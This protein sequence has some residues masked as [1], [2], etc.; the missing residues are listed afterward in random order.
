MTEEAKTKSADGRKSAG[1]EEL[2]GKVI[3]G[4]TGKV[5]L[6]PGMG[7]H[8]PLPGIIAIALYMLV[9]GAVVTFGAIGKHL[10]M[11]MLVLAPFFITASFGLLRMFRW[12]WALT[13]AAVFLLMSYNLWLFFMHQ[14]A[15]GAVQG[16]LN[17]LFFLYLVREDVRKRLR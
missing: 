8:M 3:D 12:A 5:A 14:Q 10:P 16:A 6:D 1:G 17:M 13:M 7:P 9:L 11:L 4:L 15:P 2:D